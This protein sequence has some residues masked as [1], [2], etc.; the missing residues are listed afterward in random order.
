MNNAL[1]FSLK[2]HSQDTFCEL[3]VISSPFVLMFSFCSL[4]VIV[5][6]KFLGSVIISKNPSVNL[7]NLFTLLVSLNE[8][9]IEFNLCGVLSFLIVLLLDC[10]LSMSAFYFYCLAIY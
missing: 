7:G 8:S 4:D 5:L 9:K 6:I 3:L 2:I 1:V 10:F